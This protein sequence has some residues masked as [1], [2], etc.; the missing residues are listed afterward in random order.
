MDDDFGDG[1]G[2]KDSE[3]TDDEGAGIHGDRKKM[4]DAADQD[5]RRESCKNSGEKSSAKIARGYSDALIPGAEDGHRKLRAV[6]EAEARPR[7]QASDN[8]RSGKE[9]NSQF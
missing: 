3:Q 7:A 2:E 1:S 6:G 5:S 9:N 8:R 4:N